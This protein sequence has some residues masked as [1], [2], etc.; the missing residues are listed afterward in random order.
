M[1][2]FKQGSCENSH[3]LI[4]LDE[5]IE[6]MVFRIRGGLL[7][8]KSLTGYSQFTSRRENAEP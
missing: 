8:N 7:T 4:R 3:F 2:N 5:G 6:P 1:L